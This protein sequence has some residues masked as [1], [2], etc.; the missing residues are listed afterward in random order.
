MAAKKK[1]QSYTKEQREAVL[2]D[3]PTIGVSAT[4]RKHGV[5]QTS[6]SGWLRARSREGLT[7]PAA[8]RKTP[9]TP[10]ET[11]TA[12]RT[13]SS[14]VA[15]TYTPSQ[16]AVVLE[17]AAKDGVTTASKKHGISRFSI[18]DWQRSRSDGPRGLGTD[19]SMS[20]HTTLGNP[21]VAVACLRASKNEQRLSRDAQRTAIE[22]WASRERICV[23]AWCLDLGVRCV[24][25]IAERPALRLALV[26]LREHN[27]GVLVVAKR[28]RIARDVVLA[29]S[30]ERAVTIAGARL[31]SAS[32]EGNGDSPADAFIRNVIDGAAQYE[33]GLIRARTCAALAAKRAHGERVGAVPFGFAVDAGGVRLVINE[34]E[35]ATIE[36]VRELRACGHSLRAVAGRLAV[37]GH[38]SRTGRQ[39]LAEQVS[40]MPDGERLVARSLLHCAPTTSPDSVRRRPNRATHSS[41][42][43]TRVPRSS[44]R[45]GPS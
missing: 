19:G 37:E 23:A 16:R 12:T 38:V 2:A 39:F 15:K 31:V 14:R 35:Q 43:T 9:P 3:V 20:K 7:V 21:R 30:I 45:I 32:G 4:A 13:P 18:Y 6:V 25:P 22:A 42:S 34:Q 33:H 5:P 40:R 29:A 41:R 8:R 24:S 1:R 44:A 17:D 28:D 27:A 26:A 36:R 10:H 11:P